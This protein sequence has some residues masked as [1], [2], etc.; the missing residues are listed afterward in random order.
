[1]SCSTSR[2]NGVAKYSHNKNTEKNTLLDKSESDLYLS[3]LGC[4]G[5]SSELGDHPTPLFADW[6]KIGGFPT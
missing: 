3:L 2:C 6:G 4:S 5:I 1:M